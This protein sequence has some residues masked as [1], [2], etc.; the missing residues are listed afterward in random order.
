MTHVQK[1][2]QVFRADINGLRAWAVMTVVLFHFGI[3]GFGGGFQGVDIFFVISGYLMTGIVISGLEDPLLTFSIRAF[4]LARAKRILPALL[5]VSV[6]VLLLGWWTLP[7]P[8]YRTLANHTGL[9]ILFLSNFKYW[10]EAGYFDTQSHEKWMLHTW[11]LSVEWQFYLLFPVLVWGLWR[12]RNNRTFVGCALAVLMLASLETSVWQSVHKPSMAFF[13][14]PSRAWELLTGGLVFLLAF[15]GETAITT[16]RAKH[17]VAVLGFVLMGAGFT[18]YSEVDLWPSWHAIFSVLGAALVILVNADTPLTK[19]RWAQWLG[20]RSYSVYLWHWPLVVALNNLELQSSSWAIILGIAASLLT[21]SLSYALVEKTSRQYLNSKTPRKASWVLFAAAFLTVAA[22]SYVIIKKGID[23]RVSK[24]SELL[25]NERNDHN[26]REGECHVSTGDSSPGCVYGGKN[27][28]AIVMGDSHANAIVTAV[29]AAL[30]DSSSG[31]REYS[32]SA[33]PVLLDAEMVPGKLDFDTQCFAFI[34]KT[35]ERINR[36]YPN[37]PVVII[38]RWAQYAIGRNEKPSEHNVPYV[39][40]DKHESYSSA[41]F[42]RQY[43]EHMVSTLCTLAKTRKVYVMRPVPEMIQDVPAALARKAIWGGPL[44]ITM[45]WSQYIQR[46][47]FVWD[48]QDQAHTQCGVEIVDPTRVLCS[49][50]VCHGA[51]EGH[52]LY[53]DDDH[54]S[55]HG[56]KLLSPLFRP[57]FAQ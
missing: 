43:Q 57:V 45:P 24:R 40:F 48:A 22:C 3:R 42:I 10:R 18:L 20:E 51:K 41:S 23:G 34:R 38:N 1:T 39:Y 50:G 29:A 5:G 13:L 46:Q 8:D 47:Q 4:Y 53:H 11:S 15:W 44:D 7:S 49:N 6:F 55:E 26:L 31:L 37:T 30:P 12:L 25:L 56:N 52:A 36:E 9:S 35:V 2:R 33:C 27:I 16:T 19:M 21:G 28:K 17:M 14:L 32:Y 54:L